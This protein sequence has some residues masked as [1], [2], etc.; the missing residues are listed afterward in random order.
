MAIILADTNA[1]IYFLKGDAMMRPYLNEQFAISEISEIELLGVKDIATGVLNARKTII[2]NC[3]LFPFTSEIKT[4]AI[5][6]KQKTT[7]KIPDAIIASTAIY[8]NLP[9]LTA[10]KE[11]KK[12]PG[13]S[14]ILLEL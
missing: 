14:L 1:I 9:L 3:L 12:I 13:L 11:F 7:F 2:E 4:L 6:L 8:F 5:Q 10:D